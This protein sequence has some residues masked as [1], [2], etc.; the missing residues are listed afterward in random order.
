MTT[1]TIYALT[2]PPSAVFQRSFA[3]PADARD[4][5]A[6]FRG[7]GSCHVKTRRDR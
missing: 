4:Y 6:F 7:L 2:M 3:R 5:A 1:V